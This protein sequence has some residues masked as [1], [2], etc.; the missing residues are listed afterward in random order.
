MATSN[1][2]FQQVK[3][4]LQRMDRRIDSARDTRLSGG[5]NDDTLIGGESPDEELIGA[6]KEPPSAA[7]VDRPIPRARPQARRA[8]PKPFR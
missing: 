2:T 3:S 6:P 4:I 8:T 1:K 5:V 7:E